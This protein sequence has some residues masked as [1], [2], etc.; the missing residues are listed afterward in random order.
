MP[1]LV[2]PEGEGV[3][4]V[5]ALACPDGAKWVWFDAS[6]GTA[7]DEAMGALHSGC[8]VVMELTSPTRAT[9]VVA[10]IA[11]RRKAMGAG[12]GARF[13]MCCRQSWRWTGEMQEAATLVSFRVGSETIRLRMRSA[14]T[15][16]TDH[17]MEAVVRRSRANKVAIDS[18]VIESSGKLLAF[19]STIAATAWMDA[20]AT[21]LVLVR[22]QSLTK[23]QAEQVGN[24]AKLAQMANAMRVLDPV[25]D[26]ADVRRPSAQQRPCKCTAR[27]PYQIWILQISIEGQ[28]RPVI[29]SC[30]QW[31]DV[32]NPS[33]KWPRTTAWRALLGRA[34]A[35]SLAERCEGADLVW[36]VLARYVWR[37][38]VAA[39]P[40]PR[41]SCCQRHRRQC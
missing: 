1:L 36:L 32:N 11:R 7:L 27:R 12:A 10:A 9:E 5:K 31:L 8:T 24:A 35:V 19:V 41:Y 30:F 34:L 39:D 28:H 29:A 21:G 25:L 14:F 13:F 37:S 23:L 18:E 15:L 3:Q 20:N 22:M 4:L 6:S 33:E 26:I 17:R 16:L 40:S 2:D 38:F